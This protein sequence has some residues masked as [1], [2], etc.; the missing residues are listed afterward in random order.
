MAQSSALR[1]DIG[2]VPAV[3]SV[4]AG[5]RLAQGQLA[6]QG[7]L[8]QCRVCP[9]ALAPQPFVQLALEA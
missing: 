4:N 3:L 5:R 9:G 7:P 8:G 2:A 6:Q 1:V